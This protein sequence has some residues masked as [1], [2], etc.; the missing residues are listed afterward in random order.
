MKA[1]ALKVADGAEEITGLYRG[2]AAEI[3]EID[4][5]QP[6]LVREMSKKGM[7]RKRG[8]KKKDTADEEVGEEAGPTKG[9][10][11][12]KKSAKR[13]SKEKTAQEQSSSREIVEDR[14]PAD[15]PSSLVR[16]T[17][18]PNIDPHL[19]QDL[20]E[21]PPQLKDPKA[22]LPRDPDDGTV[23][24][25]ANNGTP[26][27]VELEVDVIEGEI[28]MKDREAG[29]IMPPF[30]LKPADL[31]LLDRS[32]WHDWFADLVAYL[33]SYN[34]GPCWGDMLGCL[35]VLEGRA[36]FEE[37]K[38]AKFR[39]LSAGRPVEVGMWI[40]NYRHKHP[41]ISLPKF[42]DEWWIWWKGMQPYWCNVRDVDGTLGEVYRG[43]IG[44]NWEC[45]WKSGQNGFVSL[46]A[47]LA[48]W[49]QA[50]RNDAVLRGGWDDALE[51]VH[52]VLINLLATEVSVA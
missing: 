46:L 12:A 25:G 22:V 4:G 24:G 42:A 23:A 32:M 7:K 51:D 18:M 38:G 2:E 5:V 40:K 48:W 39:L 9:K 1:H 10:K 36:G 47:C 37:L 35:M 29:V 8:S 3:S 44:G 14:S 17:M 50:V 21:F 20:G 33:E 45:L 52:H 30:P 31:A 16:L 15:N 11:S 26:E 49:G 34:L 28:R 6:E 19:Q 43:S 27:D 13:S 41:K